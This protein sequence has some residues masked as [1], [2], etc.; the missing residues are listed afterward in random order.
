MPT[1]QGVS[2]E[3]GKRIPM[4]GRKKFGFLLFDLPSDHEVERSLSTECDVIAA[5]IA[6]RGMASR[7]KTIRV[8]SI[9]RLTSYPTY[10]YQVQFLHLAC[11]GGKTGIGLLGGTMN[12]ATVAD[13]ITKH[14]KPLGQGR[15]RVMCF[16]CCHSADGFLATK[17]KLT[18]YFTGAYYFS[19][20]R[21]SFATAMTVWT[22]FY[23]RKKL[24]APHAK[25]VADINAF[26]GKDILAFNT[27]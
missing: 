6:N 7:A 25:V 24:D 15:Q 11:H 27:Y 1:G 13:Q 3:K 21:I 12:W 16:S 23:F 8:A 26:V 20:E 14:L 17:Q 22:M 2:P 4:K 18:G 9:D 19:T 10:R 5:L